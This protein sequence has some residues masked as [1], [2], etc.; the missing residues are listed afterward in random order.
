MGNTAGGLCQIYISFQISLIDR[1]IG[2]LFH[3]HCKDGIECGWVQ[4][5]CQVIMGRPHDLW[6]HFLPV[7][8]HQEMIKLI[9]QPHGID[10]SGCNHGF[11]VMIGMC[12]YPVCKLTG[13][14]KIGD[15]GISGQHEQAVPKP[16]LVPGGPGDMERHY[17][18]TLFHL[19]NRIRLI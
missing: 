11:R 6:I 15:D 2:K 4:V 3:K 7:P 12:V 9:N 17:G 13:S 19:I 16:V 18:L 1:L 5:F 8:V 10:I 14:L